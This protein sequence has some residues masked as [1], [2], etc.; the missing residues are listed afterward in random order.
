MTKNVLE[1]RDWAVQINAYIEIACNWFQFIGTYSLARLKRGSCS[2]VSY[3]LVEIPIGG[4]LLEKLAAHRLIR[5]G[6]GRPVWGW[7]LLCFLFVIGI[8]N[9]AILAAV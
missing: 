9:A 7:S 3:G 4:E 2:A 6:E 1:I 5:S 8:L